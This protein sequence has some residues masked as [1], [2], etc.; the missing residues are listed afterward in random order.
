MPFNGSGTF[1]PLEPQ[2]PAV[3]GELIQA[4]EWNAIVEDLADGLSNAMARDGQ[5]T[6][7]ANLSMAGFKLTNLGL[8]TTAN[9]AVRYS[10]VFT[11]PTF[12]APRAAA[13]PDVGDNS[14]LLATTASVQA[15]MVAQGPLYNAATVL[16]LYD[17]C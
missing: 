12:T 3:S 4:D 10:Q 6:P 16:Y 11:N 5:S 1:S 7:T 9:D 13:S 15:V 17:N 8:G 2:Y 14:T